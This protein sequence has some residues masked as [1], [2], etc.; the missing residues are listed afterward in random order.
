V[1][2]PAPPIIVRIIETPKDPTEGLYNILISAMGVTGLL[3]AGAI[4]MGVVTAGILYWLRR[5]REAG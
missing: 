1:Q 2:Q 4:V 5:S 3:F